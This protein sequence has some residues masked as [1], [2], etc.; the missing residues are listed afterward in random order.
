MLSRLV[1]AASVLALIGALPLAAQSPSELLQKSK[2][3]LLSLKYSSADSLAKRA[4]RFPKLKPEQQLTAL[5]LRA[6]AL[7]PEETADQ[8]LDSAI[9]VLKQFIQLG[10]KS[11]AKDIAW[12]GL[13]AL[14]AGLLQANLPGKMWLGSRHTGAMLSIDGG[15]EVP[16]ANGFT[17]MVPSGNPFKI[18]IR[19]DKCATWDTTVT[20]R[21]D[22]LVRIGYRPALCVPK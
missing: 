6:A 5:Q 12:P 9:V 16:L 2:K 21:P 17:M 13:E 20:I 18:S 14:L 1:V 10:G 19:S 22:S 3:D 7:Y 8:Q 11:I 15:A 4:L